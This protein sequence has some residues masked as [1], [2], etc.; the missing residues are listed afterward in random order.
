MG[1]DRRTAAGPLGG[2]VPRLS[3]VVGR[4]RGRAAAPADARRPRGPSRLPGRPKIAPIVAELLARVHAATPD[5]RLPHDRGQPPR[6]E[7]GAR[8]GWT[9]LRA[10]NRTSESDDRYQNPMRRLDEERIETPTL[11]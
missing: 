6:G 5:T 4:V 3:A 9:W 1:G 7:E 10:S 8:P 2:V 11:G